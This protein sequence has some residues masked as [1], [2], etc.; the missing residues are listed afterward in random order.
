MDCFKRDAMQAI[1][2]IRAQLVG[3]SESEIEQSVDYLVEEFKKIMADMIAAYAA[4]K[5]KLEEDKL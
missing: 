4:E 5:I 3:L 2:K 1:D